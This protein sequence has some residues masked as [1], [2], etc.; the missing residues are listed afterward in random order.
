MRGSFAVVCILLLGLVAATA[1]AQPAYYP[2]GPQ[3]DVPVATVTG[4]GWTQCHLDTYAD[5]GADLSDLLDACP[6]THMML[7]CRPND[8]E[9]LTLL[10]AAPRS[11]VL[12]DTGDNETVT[13]N[14]NGSEW[15]FY[16]SGGDS[17][18]MG[19]AMGGDS[20]EKDSCDVASTNADYRLCWH[21]NTDATDDG[22]R[23]GND[24]EDPGD[25]NGNDGWDRIIY[26]SAAP[27]PTVSSWHL[28]FLALLL[29]AAALATRRAWARS[30]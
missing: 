17:E 24:S 29:A 11:D 4:G 9:T 3:R 8:A 6:G 21:L 26:V 23:C 28:L 2:S 18:S 16:A 22:Y 30:S 10:A 7:A 5:F 25:L 20:V 14:S 15:Y 12:T 1:S 19:F 13:T 27:V